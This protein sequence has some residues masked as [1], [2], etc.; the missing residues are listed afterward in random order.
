MAKVPLIVAVVLLTLQAP[1]S[2]RSQPLEGI[3][4]IRFQLDVRVF[5]TMAAINAAGFDLDA[6][7]LEQNPVR[8]LVRERLSRLDTDLQARL[9]KFYTVH[10]VELD[11]IK[12]QSKYLSFSLVLSG[13]PGFAFPGD[14][15]TDAPQEALDK[16]P[17][18][19]VDAQSLVG[20][21]RLVKETWEKAEL[22]RLWEEVRPFYLREVESYRPQIHSMILD[23][24]RY[25]RTEARLALDRQ[26]LFTPDL[27]NGYGIVNARNI[28]HDYFLLV[29]PTRTQ[30]KSIRGVRHEY[31][32]FMI[33]PLITKYAG[34]LPEPEPFLKMVGE[35]SNFLRRYERDFT[36]MVAES[37]IHMLELH[38]DKKSKEQRDLTV[39]AD[40]D[41]GLI[42][43]PYFDEALQK[44]EKNQGSLQEFFPVMIQ[45]IRL[46]K[47]KTRPVSLAQ[48]KQEIE[49]GQ[50]R[51]KKESDA[52]MQEQDGI[53]KDL[54][55]A[56]ELLRAKEF[57]KAK[58]ILEDVLRRD[59]A[60]PN[61]LYAMAQLASN[62]QDLDRALELYE[63]AAKNA[64]ESI[65]IKAWSFVRR[66]NIYQFQEKPALA[67][68]EWSRV[69]D[70]AGNLRGADEAAR[71]SLAEP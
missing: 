7:D 1:L 50:L 67:K 20:F 54:V 46:E 64:G 51:A 42:L 21:E 61:A 36:L 66:G 48:L 52:R 26:I 35:R 41:E 69:L 11:A 53:R 19:P 4:H 65:W 39:I 12:Q 60:N 25:M 18:I 23:C 9:R 32:H 33:D 40:Y 17:I 37:I 28:G 14:S 10:D 13:P 38:L 24:L 55:A 30:S 45:G 63:L 15:R 2:I 68:R 22:A 71:K 6:A 43:A 58:V 34:Q 31:L 8:R 27:L 44:F 70:L 62:D 49:T 47:E 57:E 59:P 16:V 56:N 3:V 5:A 29:G